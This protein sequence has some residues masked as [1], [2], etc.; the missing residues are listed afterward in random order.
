VAADDSPVPMESV[1]GTA[2]VRDH[3]QAT[4]W[5]VYTDLELLARLGC[6]SSAECQWRA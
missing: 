3:L 6:A 1:M 2:E 5:V 4:C